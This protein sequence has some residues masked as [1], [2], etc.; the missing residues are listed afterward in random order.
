MGGERGL[1]MTL[2]QSV[3]VTRITQS[4]LFGFQDGKA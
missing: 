2:P 1:Y 4:A 3:Y